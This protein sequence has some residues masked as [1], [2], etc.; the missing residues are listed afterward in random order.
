MRKPCPLYLDLISLILESQIDRQ[1]WLHFPL[2]R[3][4]GTRRV[5]AHP[6]GIGAIGSPVALVPLRRRERAFDV[7]GR[8]ELQGLR[9]VIAAQRADRVLPVA[10]QMALFAA[11]L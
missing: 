1:H 6:R 4:A 2:F 8:D 7:R 10:P 9:A 11:E 5:K 3:H